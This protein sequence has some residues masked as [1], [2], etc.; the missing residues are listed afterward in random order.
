[1]DSKNVAQRIFQVLQEN[2]E[3]LNETLTINGTYRD[4]TNKLKFL[5]ADLGEKEFKCETASQSSSHSFSEGEWLFDLVWFRMS[6]EIGKFNCIKSIDLVLESEISAKN[7]K[8][9]KVDFDKLLLVKKATKIMIFTKVDN[10]E[11]LKEIINYGKN[12]V[13][14]FTDFEK[15]DTI[16]LILFDE[17]YEGDFEL[18]PLIK[19]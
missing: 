14:S 2:R 4:F 15:G 5:I 9:F 17:Y 3:N 16:Y 10:S 1:M 13:N 11:L 6:E 7:F 18:I 19:E 12:S 8:D